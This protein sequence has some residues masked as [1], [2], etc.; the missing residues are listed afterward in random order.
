M[1]ELEMKLESQS[2]TALTG[3]DRDDDPIL[4]TTENLSS[5]QSF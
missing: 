4:E 5:G 1:K 3:D 2:D